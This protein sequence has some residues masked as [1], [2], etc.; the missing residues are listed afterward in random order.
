MATT[1]EIQ[2]GP[3]PF[4]F[5]EYDLSFALLALVRFRPSGASQVSPN[6]PSKAR[7]QRPAAQV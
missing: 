1:L 5:K 2:S 6:R 4:I 7:N 3:T